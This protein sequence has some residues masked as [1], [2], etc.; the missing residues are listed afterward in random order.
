MF[1]ESKVTGIIVRPMIFARNCSRARFPMTVSWGLGKEYCF[2]RPF[3]LRKSYWGQVRA[4]VLLVSLP[5][6]YAVTKGF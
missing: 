5:C 1:S 3:P 2:P 6:A 4:L